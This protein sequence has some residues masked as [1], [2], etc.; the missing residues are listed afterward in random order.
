MFSLAPRMKLFI[1]SF[2]DFLRPLQQKSL[3][4]SQ[5][6]S[7]FLFLNVWNFSLGCFPFTHLSVVEVLLRKNP[8]IGFG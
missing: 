3:I 6:E 4:F 2:D 1:C 8:N 7:V 5:K